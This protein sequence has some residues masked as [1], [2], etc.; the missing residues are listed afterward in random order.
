MNGDD[1]LYDVVQRMALGF[2]LEDETWPVFLAWMRDCNPDETARAW[3][4][5]ADLEGLRAQ[6]IARSPEIIIRALLGPA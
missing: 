6:W 2:A 4:E 1:L 3:T 5:T